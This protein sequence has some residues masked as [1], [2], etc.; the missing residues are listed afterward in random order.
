MDFGV[1]FH[2]IATKLTDASVSSA[3][4]LGWLSL[5]IALSDWPETIACR[6]AGQLEGLVPLAAPPW[7]AGG[8]AEGAG[9]LS[10]KT[11]AVGASV[12]V[13]LLLFCRQSS[14]CSH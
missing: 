11:L 14:P 10:S 5:G 12:S 3:F 13:G 2:H 1:T 7:V 6:L 4:L 8:A 9:S